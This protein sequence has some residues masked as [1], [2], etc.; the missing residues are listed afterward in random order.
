MPESFQPTFKDRTIGL[1][2]SSPSALLLEWSIEVGHRQ[3]LCQM[4]KASQVSQPSQI[5]N[6]LHFLARPSMV[7]LLEVWAEQDEDS[8][9]LFKLATDL[10]GAP[11]LLRVNPPIPPSKRLAEQ[12]RGI[13]SSH[14]VLMMLAV[15][16]PG[17]AEIQLWFDSLRLWTLLQA[18]RL[19]KEST[20][21]D[22]FINLIAEKLRLAADNEGEW[23]ALVSKMK[24]QGPQ[25][26]VE[27]MSLE[28]RR[29][30]VR[31]RGNETG[32]RGRFLLA[33]RKAANGEA[34][35]ATLEVFSSE[36][37]EQFSYDKAVPPQ[38]YAGIPKDF[39]W[40]PPAI[41]DDDPVAVDQL[42]AA[43]TSVVSEQA[44]STERL[45]SGRGIRLQSAEQLQ[46]LPWSWHKPNPIEKQGIDRLIVQLEQ[47]Q[48]VK[49]Q[50]L[51]WLIQVAT[52]TS[53]S[54]RQVLKTPVSDSWGQDWAVSSDLAS[55]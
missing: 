53:T 2:S 27:A 28:L 20:H 34:R 5:G 4:L 22:E 46:F 38:S 26:S 14:Q 32:E 37:A 8:E 33:L 45:L 44:S 12:F 49:L 16:R 51:A 11:N 52:I 48:E 10:R 23:L 6:C 15:R 7:H 29:G 54:M 19:S 3:I 17:D 30:A 41:A 9:N 50:L 25:L 43:A 39:T 40:V 55:L 18:F 36:I 31:H 42:L 24:P 21:Q 1:A 47:S 35:P 13:V